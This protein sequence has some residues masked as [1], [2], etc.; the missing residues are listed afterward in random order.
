VRIINWNV[1]CDCSG[2]KQEI[3]CEEYFDIPARKHYLCDKRRLE[4]VEKPGS[5]SGL[6]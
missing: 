4:R 2:L 1:T 6:S 3:S 5:Y